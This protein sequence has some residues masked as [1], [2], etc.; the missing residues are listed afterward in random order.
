M[1]FDIGAV[2]A[3]LKVVQSV[4]LVYMIQQ[5]FYINFNNI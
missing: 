3:T 1:K 2:R 4:S 5:N